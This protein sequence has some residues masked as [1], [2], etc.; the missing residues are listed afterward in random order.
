MVTKE[1]VLG[2]LSNIKHPNK[3][4]DIISNGDLQGVQI[5]ESIVTMTLGIDPSEAEMMEKVRQ[6]CEEAA[7]AIEGVTKARAIMTAKKTSAPSSAGHAP[8]KPKAIPGVKYVLA[9]ASGKGGVGKSTTA[10]NLAFALQKLGLQVGLVDC[11]VYGPS[12]SQL[13]GLQATPQFTDDDR[14]KPVEKDGVRAVSMSFLV[15][16]DTA[17]IWRG[18]MVISAIQQFLGG[19]AWDISGP[20]DVLIA[21]LPPGTGDVQ[22]TLS[23]TAEVNGAIVVSTP[24][25]LAL[26]DAR[27]AFDMFAKTNTPVLGVVENMSY[28]I[29]P[30]CGEQSNLFGHGGAKE[31]AQQRGLPFLGSV[32]LHMDIMKSAESGKPIVLSD[33]ESAHAKC[34]EEI[35]SKILGSLMKL[36]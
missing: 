5:N 33:P 12:A 20:L 29:C 4:Q 28:F 34:Y 2:A 10:V 35:A 27:K 25:D 31:I 19:V 6:Q 1:Q 23:Q 11:D 7:L 9:V 17:A 13:L 36:N 8:P 18:P 14:I 22:L 16:P 15:D 30:N 21:D 26:I 3:N 32:P 24:Q